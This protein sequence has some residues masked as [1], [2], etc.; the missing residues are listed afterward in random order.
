MSV[1]H[2]AFICDNRAP[3]S[4]AWAKAILDYGFDLVLDP[5]CSFS[6]QEGF[7]PC[8]YLGL[9]AGFEFYRG[10]LKMF[11][12]ELAKNGRDFTSAELA[13]LGDADLVVEFVTHSWADDLASAVISAG[14]LAKMTGG[15]LWFAGNRKLIHSSQAIDWTREQEREIAPLIEAEKSRPRI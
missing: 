4:T 1:V 12:G 5:D 2:Q 13:V 15:C 11:R 8:R 14:V 7:W 6:S 3:D 10:S 9:D